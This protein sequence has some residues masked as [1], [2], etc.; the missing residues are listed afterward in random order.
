MPFDLAGN[1]MGM[2]WRADFDEQGS[3]EDPFVQVYLTGEGG[4]GEWREAPESFESALLKDNY[5][6]QTR[7]NY[8]P[9]L[10]VASGIS[11]PATQPAGSITPV[12]TPTAT[13]PENEGIAAANYPPDP[14]KPVNPVTGFFDDVA[15][16][17][18]DLLDNQPAKIVD[19]VTSGG[20]A[21]GWAYAEQQSPGSAGGYTL[22]SIANP[23]SNPD[24]E[25][26][27][28]DFDIDFSGIGEGMMGMM[29][30]MMPMMMMMGM[31]SS[32]FSNFGRR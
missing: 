6:N 13:T 18:L 32:M 2:P 27:K 5:F 29:V 28:I 11:I 10:S 20:A 31:M 17:A 30:Q 14:P 26:K 19:T 16:G 8:K 4:Q 9:S 21:P 22:G 3:Y 23:E 1:L 24:F 7:V 15:A 25:P 12:A